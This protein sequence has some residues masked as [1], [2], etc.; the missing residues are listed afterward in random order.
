MWH[1]TDQT[2]PKYIKQTK[3]KQ[4]GKTKV[5]FSIEWKFDRAAIR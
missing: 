5:N 2:E 4:S 3:N 1:E